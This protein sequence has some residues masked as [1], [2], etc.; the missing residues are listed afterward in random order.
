MIISYLIPVYQGCCWQ[1]DRY[2]SQAQKIDSGFSA[3]TYTIKAVAYRVLSSCLLIVTLGQVH[4]IDSDEFQY[5]ADRSKNFSYLNL[6][7]VNPAVIM[8]SELPE[9]NFY[10]ANLKG[11]NLKKVNLQKAN[12]ESALLEKTDLSGAGLIDAI[13]NH[14]NMKS[15]KLVAARMNRAKAHGANMRGADCK[16]ADMTQVELTDAIL[17]DTTL[18][19]AILF[20]CQTLGASFVNCT[21]DQRII[22]MLAERG[23][24]LKAMKQAKSSPT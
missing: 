21:A 2:R 16:S 18:T 8:L 9:A 10:K 11:V 4:Y 7:K 17:D 1:S 6:T 20:Q 14:A 19:D 24:E 15:S 13:F 12:F 5:I 3:L 23:Y 22:H